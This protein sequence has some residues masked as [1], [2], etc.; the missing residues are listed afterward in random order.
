MYKYKSGRRRRWV[1]LYADNDTENGFFSEDFGLFTTDDGDEEAAEDADGDDDETSAEGAA[2]GS[3]DEGSDAAQP[4]SSADECMT[5]PPGHDHRRG[6][7]E[8]PDGRPKLLPGDPPPGMEPFCM[9]AMGMTRQQM[10]AE[11]KARIRAKPAALGKR[12]RQPSLQ[13][14]LSGPLSRRGSTVDEGNDSSGDDL[15]RPARKRG[16]PP[17]AAAAA[18]D[19]Q[20][21]KRGVGRPRKDADKVAAPKSGGAG[22]A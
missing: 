9:R 12:G 16:R 1:V 13:T 4:Q 8:W 6:V 15:T 21:A 10:L 2:G 5:E 3:P 11:L 14:N 22:P 18:G 17:K 7:K 19:A 20:P